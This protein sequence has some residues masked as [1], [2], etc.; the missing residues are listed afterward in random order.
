MFEGCLVLKNKRAAGYI[1]VSRLRSD[2]ATSPDN[3]K[4]KIL[5]WAQFADIDEVDFFIDLDYSGKD[6]ERPEFQRMM[7]SLD[8][9]SH[10]IVYK[11]SRFSRSTADFHSSII[12]LEEKGIDLVSV[13]ERVDTSTPVGRLIRNVLVD[14]AQFERE[15]IAEQVKDNMHKNADNGNW[16]GGFVPYGFDWDKQDKRLVVNDKMKHVRYIFETIAAGYGANTIR[17]HF[18]EQGIKS[19]MGRARWAKNTILGIVRNPAYVGKLYYGGQVR[20]GKQGQHVDPE[21]FD[22]AN[23]MAAAH[24]ERAPRTRG[25]Q[26]LLSSLIRCPYCGRRL[27]VRY[28][29]K[30]HN[31]VRRYVC[32]GRNDYAAGQRCDCPIVDAVS[33]EAAVAEKILDIAYRPESL[34]EM[35][36]KYKTALISESDVART[37]ER[38]KELLKQLKEIQVSMDRMFR[39]LRDGRITEEQLGN[40]NA[41]LLAEE[42]IVRKELEKFDDMELRHINIDQEL[43][44]ARKMFAGLKDVWKTLTPEEKRE[45][46][47]VAIEKVDMTEDGILLDC[48]Y[49]A[50]P[51]QYKDRTKTTL[52]F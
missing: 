18:Y 42:E 45:A 22:Q 21:L 9:Y 36:D 44:V 33:I 23:K 43:E 16:N 27:N 15:V 47:S 50:I 40:Q 31:P 2:D 24:G 46:I 10:V 20:G 35:L 14:F 37:G 28:N 13:S 52:I 5:Q 12:K 51:V 4:E 3:Q 8:K 7:K 19:P 30:S 29:G 32:P 41:G 49:F 6:T 39:L 17:N 11:L 1:R 48:G 38:K 25:S 34:N 26:H